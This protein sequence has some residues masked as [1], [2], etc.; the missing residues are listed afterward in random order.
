[1][2]FKCFRLWFVLDI[3]NVFADGAWLCQ[4]VN[5]ATLV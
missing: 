5:L 4:G 2:P 1:M 3:I